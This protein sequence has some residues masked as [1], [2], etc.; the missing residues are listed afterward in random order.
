MHWF[1]SELDLNQ[2]ECDSLKPFVVIFINTESATLC[3][4]TRRLRISKLI[5]IQISKQ[6]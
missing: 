5:K 1:S 4:P 3:P 2:D 6:A